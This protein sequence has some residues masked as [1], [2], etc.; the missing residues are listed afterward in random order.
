MDAGAIV[1]VNAHWQLVQEVAC[2]LSAH[3]ASIIMTRIDRLVKARRTLQLAS[4]V[5][6]PSATMLACWP[7][8][9]RCGAPDTSLAS[10]SEPD[11]CES[12]SASELEYGFAQALFRDVAYESCWCATGVSIIVWWSATGG[13]QHRPEA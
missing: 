4:V 12:E 7:R 9:Q 6:A 11:W 13:D 1:R 3:A 5:G 8:R 2:R 10:C